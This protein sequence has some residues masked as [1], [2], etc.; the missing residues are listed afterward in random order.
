MKEAGATVDIRDNNGDT[1]LLFVEKPEI[2]E[3]L[4]SLGVDARVRNNRDEN[5]VDKV[6]GDE[7]EEWWSI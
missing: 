7:N 5:V 6:V 3:L 2:Y 4:V 1:P